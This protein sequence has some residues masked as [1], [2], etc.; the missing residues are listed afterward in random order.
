MMINQYGDTPEML[1]TFG[2]FFLVVGLILVASG[3]FLIVESY[4]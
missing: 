1:F 2:I 3:A 4:G